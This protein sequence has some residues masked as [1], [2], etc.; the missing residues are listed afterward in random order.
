MRIKYYIDMKY[1]F[2]AS[3]WSIRLFVAIIIIINL[4]LIQY[5]ILFHGSIID[6]RVCY[7]LCKNNNFSFQLCKIVLILRGPTQKLLSLLCLL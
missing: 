4:L 7:V 2:V 3:I 5:I 6:E 1:K